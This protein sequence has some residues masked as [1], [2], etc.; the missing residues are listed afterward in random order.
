M[1]KPSFEFEVGTKIN[2]KKSNKETRKFQNE[3]QE[4]SRPVPYKGSALKKAIKSGKTRQGIRN[5]D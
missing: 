5:Q 3:S 4:D 1:D 2:G